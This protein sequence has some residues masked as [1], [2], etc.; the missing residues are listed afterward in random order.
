MPPEWDRHEATWM[1][2]PTE[3]PSSADLDEAGL[4]EMRSAWADVAH[5]VSRFE[6][7]RMVVDP[8]DVTSATEL[9]GPTID[10]VLAPL[11]DSWMR[12]MG[13][14]F[15]LDDEGHVAAVSWVFNGWGAQTW[16]TWEKDALVADAVAKAA[17]VAVIS[18]PMVNEGGGIHVDGAGTVLLTETVQRGEGRNPHWSRAEVE[19]ELARTIGTSRAVWID[20]GL[21]R[22]YEEFGTRGHVDIVAAF[23][24]P[25]TL[26]VHDQRDPSHP[27][28]E[29]TAEVLEAVSVL[30]G[31]DVVRVPAPTVLR[32]DRGWVD[33]SYINHYVVNGG[34]VLCSFD[35]PNDAVAAEILGACYPEREIVKVDARPIFDRGGGI[36]CITQQQPQSSGAARPIPVP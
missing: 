23:A 33:W 14:T 15:V 21:T 2:W 17:G 26:V 22:D 5:A 9:L 30:E 16:S 19:A 36:H 28:Y 11:D 1:A 3:G 35:D 13:P 31:I 7:V 32:D 8:G 20:R 24:G 4:V 34:V 18:S 29:V 10:L 27:D 25:T 12:D 6:P